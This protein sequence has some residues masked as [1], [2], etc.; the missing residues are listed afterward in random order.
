MGTQVN[1]WTPG[2]VI[3]PARRV[4]GSIDLD[5]ASCAAA[6]ETVRAAHYFTVADDGLSQRWHGNVWMNHPWTAKDNPL[7]IDKLVSEYTAGNIA[8]AVCITQASVNTLWFHRL[9]SYPICFPKRRINF[10]ELGQ[11]TKNNRYETAITYLGRRVSAFEREFGTLGAIMS[12]ANMSRL[13]VTAVSCELCGHSFMQRRSDQ[14]F[15]N[16]TCRQ[17]AKRQR[18]A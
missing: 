7:W 18:A 13:N 11:P 15:C 12:P 1:Y 9:M 5:P 16:A 14:R 17:R 8:A 3:E 10:Y 4:L 2:Y 6:N